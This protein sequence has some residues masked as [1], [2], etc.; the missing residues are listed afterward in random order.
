MRP[1]FLLLPGMRVGLFG[2]SF[3]PA[4]EGHAHV[5]QTALKRLNL[6]RLIWLVS[7]QNPL[8]PST[9]TES[10][11]ARMAGA[12]RL[13]RGPS[14]IVS[15]VEAQLGTRYT[16]DT[17]RKFQARYPGVK[18]VWVMGADNLGGLHRWRDWPDLMR[19]M[20]MAVVARPGAGAKARLAAAPRRFAGARRRAG[21]AKILPLT[22]APAWVD[23]AA[24]LH[25]ASSTALRALAKRA[26]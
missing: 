7:P 21:E 23:L 20:P 13:A 19:S 14:M 8:K 11:A 10:L 2:G 12:S 5:A 25:S 16:A 15:A 17:L 3:N 22:G 9:E 1:G 26:R 24:P 18:F 6:H 4:H